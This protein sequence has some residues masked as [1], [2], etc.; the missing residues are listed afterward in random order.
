MLTCACVVPVGGSGDEP[1][2]GRL[3]GVPVSDRV[4]GSDHL[5]LEV[6]AHVVTR[7]DGAEGCNRECACVCQ[8]CVQG[9]WESSCCQHEVLPHVVE[10]LYGAECCNTECACV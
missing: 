7:Q 1:R 4:V 6:L 8:V 5:E 3:Q 2:F 10:R 9:T